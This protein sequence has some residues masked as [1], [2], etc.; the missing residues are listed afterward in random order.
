MKLSEIH[1]NPNN[2][3]LIKNDKFRKLVRSV[4]DFPKMMELRPIIV[5][6]SGMILGGN[7]RYLACKELGM[8]EI[9]DEWVKKA[10]EL[11]DEEKRRF[12]LTDNVEYGEWDYEILADWD[13]EELDVFDIKIKHTDEFEKEFNKYSN[14]NCEYPIIPMYDEKNEV[15]IIVSNS[16]IDSNHLREILNMQK[17]KSYKNNEI[18]KSNVIKIEDVINAIKNS[19]T[20]S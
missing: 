17:M 9:P 14:D 16:E 6:D 2:P 7:M 15:F 1:I 20:F 18:I 12:I 4:K 5:D 19:N 11:S 10:S 13:K 8:K 3:R